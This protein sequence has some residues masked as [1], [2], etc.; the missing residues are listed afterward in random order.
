[1]EWAK[2]RESVAKVLREEL[3][4]CDAALKHVEDSVGKRKLKDVMNFV[5]RVRNGD[6]ILEGDGSGGAGGFSA[7]LLERG[8]YSLHAN[9]YPIPS[10]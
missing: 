1:M 2:G 3:K 7:A 10:P 9:I 4:A 5:D 6:V 8:P